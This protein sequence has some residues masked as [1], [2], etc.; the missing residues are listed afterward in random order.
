LKVLST[1]WRNCRRPG[2]RS[3]RAVSAR[4]YSGT[5]A[6]PKHTAT[7]RNGA[8][9]PVAATGLVGKSRQRA[10]T[11]A[12]PPSQEQKQ[13]G[14]QLVVA[15][16]AGWWHT[17]AKAKCTLGSQSRLAS[18]HPPATPV[19]GCP[20]YRRP[21]RC[22]FQRS[23][24]QPGRCWPPVARPHVTVLAMGV[25]RP[26]AAPGP[27]LGSCRQEAARQRASAPLV[28]HSSNSITPARC[29]AHLPTRRASQLKN[30]SLQQTTPSN[31]SASAVP[32]RPSRSAAAPANSERR[33]AGSRR[34]ARQ[35]GPGA[36][37]DSSIKQQLQGHGKTQNGGIA[38]VLH[39]LRLLAL[40]SAGPCW[41]FLQVPGLPLRLLP[42]LAH[43]RHRRLSRLQARRG[44][45]T[46]CWPLT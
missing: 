11:R 20:S 19:V 25:H 29:C 35:Q 28:V 1:Q 26:H 30:H 13:I 12:T 42:L 8:E 41:P 14:H 33:A 34:S 32:F 24:G 18:P 36:R 4:G 3:C 27:V 31:I 10:A 5:S 44:H 17:A 9:L 2:V 46:A 16:V 21:A 38:L 39:T 22:L 37:V 40:H 23:V 15:L 43:R 6:C 45:P 7:K